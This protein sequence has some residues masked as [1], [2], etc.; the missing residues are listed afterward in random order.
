[1]I[2]DIIAF[3]I[4]IVIFFCAFFLYMGGFNIL[5]EY[6]K[7]K[8]KKEKKENEPIEPYWRNKC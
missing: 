2:S 8:I 6:R 3:I 4:S 5:I 7:G 1:M